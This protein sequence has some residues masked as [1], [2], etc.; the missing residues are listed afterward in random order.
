VHVLGGGVDVYQYSFVTS[1]YSTFTEHLA[2]R[3]DTVFL[4]TIETGPDETE[5]ADALSDDAVASDGSGVVD[6]GFDPAEQNGFDAVCELLGIG[7]RTPPS[8]VDLSHVSSSTKRYAVLLESPEPLPFARLRMT[9]R[10]A[11]EGASLA[12]V[13]S[14]SVLRRA[15]GTAMLI[16]IDDGTTAAGNLP[17]G[18]YSLECALVGDISDADDAAIVWVLPDGASEELA[19]LTFTLA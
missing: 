1:R 12:P 5:L 10:Y 11:A 16:F 2:D 18:S 19:T 15:D 17:A 9:L 13:A 3:I 14:W 4:I 7:A 8:R 6:R